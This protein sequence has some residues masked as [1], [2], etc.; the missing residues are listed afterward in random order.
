MLACKR[1]K[2]YR[3]LVEKM[4]RAH[5][6]SYRVES[7]NKIAISLLSIFNGQR[8]KLSLSCICGTTAFFAWQLVNAYLTFQS[9]IIT[10]ND[11]NQ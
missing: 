11:Y 1:K 9:N 2:T 4:M 6:H 3:K 8:L 10:R 7:S 5:M